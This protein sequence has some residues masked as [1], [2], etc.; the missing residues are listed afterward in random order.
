[1]HKL[2]TFALLFALSVVSSIWRGFVLSVLWEWFA[3]PMHAPT[4]S[5]RAATALIVVIG[6][7]RHRDSDVD[8]DNIDWLDLSVNDTVIP[9]FYLALGAVIHS[10]F[11]IAL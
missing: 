1:M 10:F 11:P 7:L 6:Y 2:G 4:L 9:L 5:T 3:V 8:T